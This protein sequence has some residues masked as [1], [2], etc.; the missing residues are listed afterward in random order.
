MAP[1]LDKAS[2]LISA[3]VSI[4]G[5]EVVALVDTGATTSCCRWGWYKEWKSHLG[6]LR[7]SST[8]VVGVGNVP[9]EVKGLS[10]PL[11]LQWDG[12]EGQCQL[13]VLTTLTDVDVVLGMD[14]LSQFD[15][16]IDSR[17]QVASPERE[18]CAPL[19]LTENVGLL[20]ENPTFTL[21]GKIPV[22]EEEAEE[23]I[24]GVHRQGHLG[25]HK[26]W[27][28][29]NRKFITTEGRRKCRKIVH[30]CPE[31]RLGKDYR[32]RHLPKGSIRSS[33]PW[34]QEGYVKQLKR[35]LEDIRAKLSRI[36]DQ[37]KVISGGPLLDLWGQRS[38]E[39]GGSCDASQQQFLFKY[40]TSVRKLP[41][42]PTRFK[43]A[44][45]QNASNRDKVGFGIK[46]CKKAKIYRKKSDDKF[47]NPYVYLIMCISMICIYLRK[48]VNKW[49][50]V[51]LP[52]ITSGFDKL[53]AKV[54]MAPETCQMGRKHYDK[55]NGNFWDIYG[56]VK[57][58]ICMIYMYLT[59][60]VNRLKLVRLQT[61]TS[62]LAK[63]YTI[64]KFGAESC[65]MVRKQ[66][67][68][69]HN[70]LWNAY[71][72]LKGRIMEFGKYLHTVILGW[73]SRRPLAIHP[74]SP[75]WGI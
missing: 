61:R 37:E 9:I 15:V 54:K 74:P 3:K 31:C 14:V 17:N 73:R 35:E 21:K 32:Q 6:S 69:F 30:T 56:Y 47:W 41:N 55:S 65:P 19:I 29:F 62:D 38:E 25:E 72:Y 11:M 48:Q 20:L 49:Q 75:G 7:H 70:I 43:L 64:D 28:A 40:K 13:M 57:M 63:L 10:K 39:E 22:K 18:L 8:M 67:H 36:L 66:I 34:D 5:V 16:K 44:Y 4:A 26:T 53:Y 23:V 59:K 71:S 33:R 52:T 46:S 50:P 45:V 68:K 2:Q 1:A 58:Y 24:K 51:E 42:R 27:K 60:Q 12:V